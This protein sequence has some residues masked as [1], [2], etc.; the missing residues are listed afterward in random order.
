M[1]RSLGASRN[2]AACFLML[3]V[4]LL[5]SRV[6]FA[7]SGLSLGAGKALGGDM[8]NSVV[9]LSHSFGAAIEPIS[10]LFI[11]ALV[12]LGGKAFPDTLG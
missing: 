6:V 10:I 1:R 11:E 7:D 5:Y 3:A 4:L 9:L 8:F 2:F 12:S